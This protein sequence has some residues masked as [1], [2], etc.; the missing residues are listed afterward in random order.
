MLENVN[1]E[2][3]KDVA[4]ARL[5]IQMLLNLVEELSSA[6]EALRAEVQ[7]LRDEVNRA[8]RA[9]EGEQG[10]PSIKPSAKP[11]QDHSSEKER[12]VPKEWQKRPKR[13]K[14]VIHREEKLTVDKRELP[15]DAEFKGYAEVVVQDIRITPNNTCFIKE[16]YYS[17]SA[18]KSYLA[19]MPPGY[20]GEF[21]PGVRAL[22][23]TF[24]HG[25]GMTEPKIGEFLGHFEIAIS[26]GQISNLLVK[27]L[28]P[29]HAEKA[30]VRDAGLAS[31]T[32]QHCD[33]TGTR[34]NGVNYYCHILC[35]PYYTAY[36][37]RPHKNRLTLIHLLQGTE[38][39]QLQCTEQ[40]QVWFAA[41]NTPLWARQSVAQWFQAAPLTPEALDALIQRDMPR[42]NDQQ[43]A[44]IW[45]ATALTAYYAQ[46]DTPVVDILL[47]DDAPQFAQITPYHALCW[48]HEG[49]HYKKL[50]PVVPYHRQRLDTF[51]NDFWTFYRE[52][53]AY[54]QAPH[55]L[56]A[57][58]LRTRFDALFSTTTGY[59][60]LDQRI[61]KTKLKAENLLVV[62]DFPDLPLHN[63]PAELGARQRVRKRTISLGPVTQEGLEA[64]D[65]FMTLAETAKK[66][67]VN[68]FAYIFD[69]VSQSYR[70]PSLAQM[71]HQRAALAPT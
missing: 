21:G 11:E 56:E 55:L 33:D 9:P 26:A 30:A 7:A 62:L 66:L 4:S 17:P 32:W 3:I 40:T 42:L 41:F 5:T 27:A 67:G 28:E 57:E 52:L 47:T 24:Y 39:L 10:K 19:P 14:L 51:L 63:N 2:T 65:T 60:E 15:A 44:R 16:K 25:C 53:L 22:I 49:R 8:Q 13:A 59:H 43:Q 46:T 70:L 61:A 12:R 71:I 29:W 36:F 1:P 54:R 68:F 45:E 18:G 69:R 6:N 38:Q 50:L 20:E 48:V 37:T 35:N 31:T 23:I 64:W 58:R 34:V